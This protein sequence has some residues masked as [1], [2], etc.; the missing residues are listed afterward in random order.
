MGSPRSPMDEQDPA[1]SWRAC[2]SPIFI[3]L[4]RAFVPESLPAKCYLRA[5]GASCF[6]PALYWIHQP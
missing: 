2:S 3:T 5:Y 6:Y 4:I 1:C